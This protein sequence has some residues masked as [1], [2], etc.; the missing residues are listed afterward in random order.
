MTELTLLKLLEKIEVVQ[1][2]TFDLGNL[3]EDTLETGI[4]KSYFNTKVKL[5]IER[6]DNELYNCQRVILWDGERDNK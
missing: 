6:I 1:N 3:I 4:Q 5:L 2:A